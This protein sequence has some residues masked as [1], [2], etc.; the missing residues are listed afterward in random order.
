MLS[1]PFPT[2]SRRISRA[3]S[4]PAV[5]GHPRHQ[6]RKVGV[7]QRR[8]RCGS[9]FV[10]SVFVLVRAIVIIAIL[11]SLTAFV[12]NGTTFGIGETV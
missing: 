4:P 2:H 10:R 8:D 7:G 1:L 5:D 3:A 11:N 6:W 12:S 9:F